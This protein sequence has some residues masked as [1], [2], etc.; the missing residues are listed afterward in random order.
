MS[1]T[2][3][4]AIRRLSTRVNLLPVI[5]RADTLTTERL[6]T[7]KKVIKRDLQEA[8]IGFGVFAQDQT[9]V[10][11]TEESQQQS[12]AP[13]PEEE[14]K[15]R[16]IIKLKAGRKLFQMKRSRSRKRLE[17]EFELASPDNTVDGPDGQAP[18]ESAIL[19]ADL[20]G[21]LP[22]AIMSPDPVPRN[23]RSKSNR[24]ANGQKP[25]AQSAPTSPMTPGTTSNQTEGA[26]NGEKVDLRGKFLRRFRWGVVDVLNP[27]HCD[28]ATLRATILGSMMR[29]LRLNT[30]QVIYENYR[31]EKLLARRAT[32]NISDDDRKRLLQDLGI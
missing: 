25:T 15:S 6:A 11:P 7:V 13:E 9:A 8:G 2:E 26:P 29:T 23:P 3:I 24:T 31:T 18:L 28:V 19:P 17:E 5:A 20:T 1:P 22:F 27:E 12:E 30:K 10:T 4:R 16:P 21:L 14:R 32:R